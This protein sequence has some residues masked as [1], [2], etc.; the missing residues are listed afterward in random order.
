MKIAISGGHLTPALALIDY[1]Q[2]NHPQDEL[3]FIGRIFSQKKLQQRAVEKREAAKRGVEFIPFTAVKWGQGSILA[4]LTI[5]PVKFAV[6]VIRALSILKQQQPEILVSFG[7]YLAVPLAIAARLSGV[8]IVTHEGT[9]VLGWSN[10]MIIP[11]ASAAA[12]SYQ[13]VADQ[14]KSSQVVVTGTPI[15]PEILNPSPRSPN[16]I[17]SDQL[18]KPLLLVM[19]GNQG[20][21]AINQAIGS[22]LS[23]LLLDWTVVHICG[24]ANLKDNYQQQLTTAAAGLPADLRSRYFVKTWLEA[25]ELSW[26]YQQAYGA[27]SRAGAN[28]TE[29]LARTQVPTIFIPLPHAHLD[30]QLKNASWLAD[31]DAAL[32]LPE[33]ELSSQ[34]LLLSLRQLKQQHQLLKQNLKKIELPVNG[35]EQLYQLAA[36]CLDE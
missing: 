10:R 8:K 13:A 36:S 3:V 19:G 6:S 14:I 2:S 11:L 20:S 26:L 4:K 34:T 21:K 32:I 9:R 12:V 25:D 30:E 23:E 22:V 27:V 29:E 1:V 7:G 18:D 28:T 16:W 15:R 24:R 17:D 35:A 5:K 31:R 33:P